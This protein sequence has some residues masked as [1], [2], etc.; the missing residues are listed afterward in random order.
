MK[1]SAAGAHRMLS[2]IYGETV[3]SERTCGFNASRMV[4]LTSKTGMAVKERRLFKDAELE[5]LLHEDSCRTQEEL[6][7]A[8]GVTQRAISKFGLKA[9]RMIQKQRNWVSYDSKP[10][11]D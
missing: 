2:N 7:G 6:A 3:I 1:K 8:L 5:A 11:D 9:M 10:R 4:I